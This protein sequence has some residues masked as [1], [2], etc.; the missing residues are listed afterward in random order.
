MDGGAV[1]SPCGYIWTLPSG[2][3]SNSLP[4][5]IRVGVPSGMRN[6]FFLPVSGTPRLSSGGF[7][8]MTSDFMIWRRSS[9]TTPSICT[10]SKTSRSFLGRPRY[11]RRRYSA[12][13]LM[14]VWPVAPKSIGTRS[15]CW[16]LM[17]A[18]TRSLDVI[19]IPPYLFFFGPRGRCPSA[20]LCFLAPYYRPSA[21]GKESYN[22][23]IVLDFLLCSWAADN[24]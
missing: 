16:W 9:S 7:M 4:A 5:L 3:I 2:R 18:R 14:P 1:R 24:T 23:R 20:A 21:R 17:A 11:S 8:P 6:S 22:L 15:G 12:Q 10:I 19:S 13:T